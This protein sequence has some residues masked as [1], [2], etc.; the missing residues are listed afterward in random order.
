MEEDRGN[1]FEVE[2]DVAAHR[3]EL[4]NLMQKIDDSQGTV[5]ALRDQI[6]ETQIEISHIQQEIAEL[7]RVKQMRAVE[8]VCFTECPDFDLDRLNPEHRDHVNDL[9]DRIYDLEQKLERKEEKSGHLGAE[10]DALS[11]ENES[12]EREIQK[13]KASIETA[14]RDRKHVRNSIENA[15]QRLKEIGI[16]IKANKQSLTITESALQGLIG[17]QDSIAGKSGGIVDLEKSI[18]SL[19]EAI[20]REQDDLDQTTG[21]TERFRDAM[22]EEERMIM[23]RGS[24][25]TGMLNWNSE[26][27]NLRSEI[28]SVTKQLEEARKENEKETQSYTK[29]AKRMRELTNLF[30][31]WEGKTLPETASDDRPVDELLAE[32][33]RNDREKAHSAEDAK[34]ALE[35]AVITNQVLEEKIKRKQEELDRN[36]ALF[37][38]DLKRLKERIDET[39]MRSFEEEHSLV[40]QI[41]A[42]KLKIAQQKANKQQL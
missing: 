15:Q 35:Q 10:V 30:N 17:R 36:M 19:Q 33:V 4:E 31:K 34:K 16:T 6:T 28:S 12:L 8:G 20:S 41:Q 1:L 7:K 11:R 3:D 24:D 9:M 38:A 5:D 37:H 14:K 29:I 27:E 22:T 21:D 32:L 26:R 2:S 23:E 13:L 42:L 40:S 25:Y 18:K 39:R